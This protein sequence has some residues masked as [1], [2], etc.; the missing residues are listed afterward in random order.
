MVQRVKASKQVQAKTRADGAIPLLKF[1][2][3]IVYGLLQ[4]YILL[5]NIYNT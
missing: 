5:R 3:T 1:P 4:Q 2:Y